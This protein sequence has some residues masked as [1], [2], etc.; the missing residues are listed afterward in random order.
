MSRW[1]DLEHTGA[2]KLRGRRVNRFLLAGLLNRI[3]RV[4]ENVGN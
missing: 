2:A 3:R 4:S 1:K